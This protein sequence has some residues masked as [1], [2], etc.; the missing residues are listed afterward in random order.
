MY[1]EAENLSH[2]VRVEE[3][4][5]NSPVAT[6]MHYV[7]NQDDRSDWAQP[8]DTIIVGLS[9]KDGEEFGFAERAQKYAREG[10]FVE[11]GSD[12]AVSPITDANG[13]VLSATD[14]RIAIANNDLMTF[15][16]FIPKKLRKQA[17]IIL[18]MIRKY[19]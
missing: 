4:P 2:K 7:A 19:I 12:T 9:T 1:L 3:S 11:G 14:M 6:V 10:V 17:D 16:E 5:V 15:R 18:H 8:G 13:N